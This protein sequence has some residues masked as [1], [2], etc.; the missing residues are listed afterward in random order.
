MTLSPTTLNR[1]VRAADAEVRSATEGAVGLPGVVAG[2][3]DEHQTR[4][5]GCSGVRAAGE[6]EQISTD[7]VLALYSVTKSLTATL[8]LQLA[9][10][11]QLD[12]D[13]PAAD[14]APRLTKIGVLDGFDNDGSPHIRPPRTPVTTRQLLTHT[15]GFGYDFFD[16]NLA[17]ATRALQLPDI[18]TA[19]IEAL[20]TPLLF[21]PGTRWS[22]GMSLDWVGLVIEG[23]TGRRLGTVMNERLL[24]PLGMRDTGFARDEQMLA[25]AA[26]IHVRTADR[27]LKALRRPA[28]PDAPAM[29]MGG[30]GLYSTVGDFLR[31]IRMWLNE[32]RADSGEQ[33]VRADTVRAATRNHLG[34]LAVTPLPGVNPR[35]THDVDFFPG[36]DKGWSLIGM[37]ITD[38]APT[39][40]P[41]GS[42]GWAG[43]ANL[44]F[45]I[46]RSNGLGGLWAT[47]LFP[48]GDPAALR[49]ALD[50]EKAV[51]RALH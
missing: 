22:Y 13:A 30:Q 43:L 24:Q 37:V 11:G 41:A 26:S 28:Q 4:Y 31:F 51:Y 42:P 12:L 15:A 18:A 14:Y 1:L 29:D 2:L 23:L 27:G 19:R 50:F 20:D 7:A 48:F 49:A 10:D 40:R 45:W 32:G 34:D 5:L 21:D 6:P 25:R 36:V 17:A 46:D 35:L 47:Q 39:G 44:Y 33:V 38:D 16:A 8:A 3:T 9:D